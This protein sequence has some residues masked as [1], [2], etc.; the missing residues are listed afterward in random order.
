MGTVIHIQYAAIGP[1]SSD[2]C[3]SSTSDA[4]LKHGRAPLLKTNRVAV[5]WVTALAVVQIAKW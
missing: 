1:A 4:G 3:H 5:L 2:D